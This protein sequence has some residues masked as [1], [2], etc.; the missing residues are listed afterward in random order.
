MTERGAKKD[1]Y[2]DDSSPSGHRL[3][4]SPRHRVATGSL[5]VAATADHDLVTGRR[6]PIMTSSL[7]GDWVVVTS[8]PC[9]RR[10]RRHLTTA[11]V[12][13]SSSRRHRLSWWS[14]IAGN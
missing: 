5:S 9:R 12:A 4:R 7:G 1:G 11:A 10:H 2:V 13:D 6:P 14:I 3:G 8:S